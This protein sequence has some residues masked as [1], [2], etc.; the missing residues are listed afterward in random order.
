MSNSRIGGEAKKYLAA[1]FNKGKNRKRKRAIPLI[2]FKTSLILNHGDSLQ[3]LVLNKTKGSLRVCA[4]K[5]PGHGAS[6]HEMLLDL[7]TIN[8]LID[9]KSNHLF[10][11]I[12]DILLRFLILIDHQRIKNKF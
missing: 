6:R 12:K 7:Q 8:I 1:I 4:I 5:S 11:K 3:G 2:V 10:V 9:F